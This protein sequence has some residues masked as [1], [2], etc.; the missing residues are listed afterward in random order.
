METQF[1]PHIQKNEDLEYD[2][3]SHEAEAS[4]TD[5]VDGQREQG[6]CVIEPQPQ[7]ANYY[8]YCILP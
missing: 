8:V 5:R 6:M 4:S 2:R 1:H 7:Q 3:E